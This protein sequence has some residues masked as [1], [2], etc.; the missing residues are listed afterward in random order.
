M[1]D[2]GVGTMFEEALVEVLALR[3]GDC[4]LEEAFEAA[5][6]FSRALHAQVNI[7]WSQFTVAEDLK[8]AGPPTAHS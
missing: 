4:S 7:S 5:D 1:F 3:P 6:A 8:K 2:N